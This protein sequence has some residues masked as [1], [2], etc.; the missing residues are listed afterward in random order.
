MTKEV[1]I[2]TCGTSL[3]FQGDYF[4][5]WQRQVERGLREGKQSNVEIYNFGENG[6]DS[7][8]GLSFLS[9]ALI[10]RPD[11]VVFEYCMNDAYVIRSISAAQA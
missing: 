1:R 7:Q 6:A 11:I 2:A 8:I 9:R 4:G 10:V 5:L 3:T